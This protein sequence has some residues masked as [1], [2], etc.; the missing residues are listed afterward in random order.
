M[1]KNKH[2]VIRSDGREYQISNPKVMPFGT[3]ELSKYRRGDVFVADIRLTGTTIT[4]GDG[5]VLKQDVSNVSIPVL[6]MARWSSKRS[7][8][9]YAL[10]EGGWL[11]PALLFQGDM[12]HLLDRCAVS[13]LTARGRRRENREMGEQDFF[14]DLIASDSKIDLTMYLMEGRSGRPPS[15]REVCDDYL[16]TCEALKGIVERKRIFPENIRD[17]QFV[18]GMT[19]GIWRDD[20]VCRMVGFTKE[21][22]D[23]LMAGVGRR[24]WPELSRKLEL[25]RKSHDV[26]SGSFFYMAALSAILSPQGQ[27]P[28][29]GILKPK[30]RPSDADIYNSMSDLNALGGLLATIHH[31]PQERMAYCTSDRQL[32]LFWA[33]L[34]PKAVSLTGDMYRFEIEEHNTLFAGL[35]A[36]YASSDHRPDD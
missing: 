4:G 34:A 28:A 30:K 19:E 3:A 2:I 23:L 32:A 26:D 17:L 8:T 31:R 15:R 16:E 33:G 36:F 5:T 22:N 12:T 18:I 14:D 25:S 11:P 29:R 7:M 6:T 10:V 1:D 21:V 9:S 20:L 13:E 35:E 24:K 27:N